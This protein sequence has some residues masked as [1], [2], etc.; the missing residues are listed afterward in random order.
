[1]RTSRTLN[2][3]VLLL[4]LLFLF[5]HPFPSV[6]G[7]WESISEIRIVSSASSQ[8]F[9]TKQWDISLWEMKFSKQEFFNSDCIFKFKFKFLVKKYQHKLLLFLFLIMTGSSIRI[10]KTLKSEGKLNLPY[11]QTV[12]AKFE[13]VPEWIFKK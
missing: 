4:L 13:C 7:S 8:S 6:R 2:R 9:L 11:N 3:C 12:F 1:M 10:E 5:V